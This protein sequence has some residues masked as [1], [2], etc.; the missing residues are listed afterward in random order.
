MIISRFDV[1]QNKDMRKRADRKA[2][3]FSDYSSKDYLGEGL[4]YLSF[5][6]DGVKVIFIDDRSNAK[7]LI[8]ECNKYIVGS[9]V[10]NKIYRQ[11]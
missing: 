7:W 9:G 6:I 3:K 5:I 8:S 1:T 2:L 4:V 10:L 11:S